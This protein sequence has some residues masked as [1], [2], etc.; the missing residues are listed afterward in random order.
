MHLVIS[1]LLQNHVVHDQI[2]TARCRGCSTPP[3]LTQSSE[4]RQARVT[5]SRPTIAFHCLTAAPNM[6]PFKWTILGYVSRVDQLE[7]L[8][9]RP[10]CQS[11]EEVLVTRKVDIAQEEV[12]EVELWEAI[13]EE[14]ECIGADVEHPSTVGGRDAR[15]V[16]DG[17]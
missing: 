16:G 13:V 12:H 15:D 9:G 2:R 5:T 6:I 3:R 11:R 1:I 10:E 17:V 4:S 8:H 7:M 14:R